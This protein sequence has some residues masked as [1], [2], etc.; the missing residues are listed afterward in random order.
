MLLC[1]TRALTPQFVSC[2]RTMESCLN[3][4]PERVGSVT[5]ED[6]RKDLFTEFSKIHASQVT[7]YSGS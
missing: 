1:L 5:V 3:D 7:L 2:L 4:K 6:L